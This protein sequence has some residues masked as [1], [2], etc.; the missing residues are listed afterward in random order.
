MLKSCGVGGEL[1]IL[2]IAS[3]LVLFWL[4]F[5][6]LT[7]AMDQDQDQSLTKC[8]SFVLL[9]DWWS[10]ALIWTVDIST[11]IVVQLESRQ[12]PDNSHFTPTL[13]SSSMNSVMDLCTETPQCISGNN[14]LALLMACYPLNFYLSAI[15]SPYRITS[16]SLYLLEVD[17]IY[18]DLYPL[19]HHHQN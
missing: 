17:C 7:N 13:K 6:N 9:I 3:A 2:N 14:R 1:C 5:L 12:T 4:W 11:K 19:Y 16:L 18:I 10:V 15:I 8:K